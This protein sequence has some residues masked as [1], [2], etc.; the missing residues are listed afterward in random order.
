LTTNQNVT[1]IMKNRNN[2]VVVAVTKCRKYAATEC[3]RNNEETHK[4]VQQCN[5]KFMHT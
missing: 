1:E 5:K 4:Q 3:D 2:S